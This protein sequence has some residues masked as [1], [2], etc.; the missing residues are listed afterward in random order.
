MWRSIL[1]FSAA[2]VLLLFALLQFNRPA[3]TNP[4]SEPRL[5]L[6]AHA[7]V[8]TEINAL[9]DRACRDCHSNQTNWPWYSRVAPVAWLVSDDVRAGR[10]QLNFSEWGQYNARQA[11]QRLE[12]ICAVVEAGSMPPK[13]Y[14][15]THPT[16]KL[17]EAEV[18]ALCA[19]TSQEQT[20]L[21]QSTPAQ[22]QAH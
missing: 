12:E 22:T 5:A 18:K 15:V 17:T 9:F 19:W 6:Q 11:A 8:P 7:Q 3:Q 10:Q 4:A 13:A 21:A 14:L 2:L 1:K 16:A 20:R